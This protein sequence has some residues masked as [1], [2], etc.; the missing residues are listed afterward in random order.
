MKWSWNN[1]KYNEHLLCLMIASH[2]KSLNLPSIDTDK[3]KQA[4][5]S[6]L[7]NMPVTQLAAFSKFI[8]CG[9]LLNRSQYGNT[10]NKR[11]YGTLSFISCVWFLLPEHHHRSETYY[12]ASKK[13]HTRS[14]KMNER[15][16]KD[17][18]ALEAQWKIFLPHFLLCTK[19]KDSMCSLTSI[20]FA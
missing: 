4:S 7:Q 14:G 10:E 15:T 6:H 11:F 3:S 16:V 17:E 9:I 12:I 1:K 13:T 18:K 5:R 8:D 19:H 2:Y 20:T